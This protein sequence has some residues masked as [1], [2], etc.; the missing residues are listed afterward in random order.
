MLPVEEE[1]ASR[2]L[3]IEANNPRCLD[4]ESEMELRTSLRLGATGGLWDPGPVVADLAVEFR[5][6]DIFVGGVLWCV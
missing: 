3:E 6:L 1:E 5:G 2:C 4:M